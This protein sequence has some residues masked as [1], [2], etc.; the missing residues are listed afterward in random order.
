MPPVEFSSLFT[1]SLLKRLLPPEKTDQFFEALF[2]DAAE[3]AYDIALEFRGGTPEKLE[4]EFHL[5]P[6]PG[7]CLVC[8][9]TYGLPNVFLRHPV[10]D[11]KGIA[12]EIAQLLG[13]HVQIAH[14][15]CGPT[16]ERTPDLHVI[17]LFLEVLPS[18]ASSGENGPQSG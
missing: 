16:L 7:K 14:W 9:L 4:F 5:T 13:E 11:V 17:P 6:K 3:G 15:Y 18:T 2:G 1:E 8:N 12:G 10:I